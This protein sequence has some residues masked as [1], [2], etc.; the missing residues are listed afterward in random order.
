MSDRVQSA[1]DLAGGQPGR[2][3]L[4]HLVLPAGQLGK[5]RSSRRG[6]G[7]GVDDPAG[8]RTPV[9]GV[10]AG[11]RQHRPDDLLAVGALEQ[12]A[13]RSGPQRSEQ[14]P[15]VAIALWLAFTG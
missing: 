1:G 14:G 2:E 7:Q 15:V 5:C 8:D 9:D 3:Q 6:P 4:E 11:D 13:A 10:A 12:V